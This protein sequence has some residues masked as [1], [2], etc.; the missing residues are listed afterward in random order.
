MRNPYC[1]GSAKWIVC[2][3]ALNNKLVDE[4]R[5]S[6]EQ[7]GEGSGNRIKQ[8]ILDLRSENKL[9]IKIEGN[10]LVYH[11]ER[12]KGMA[13]KV[14]IKEASKEMRLR[15]IYQGADIVCKIHVNGYQ[16][17]CICDD[18]ATDR[19]IYSALILSE[20]PKESIEVSL[21]AIKEHL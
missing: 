8:Y 16:G 9:D 20:K 13:E 7:L 4:V 12:E 10:R 6:L 2:E 1:V 3:G 19:T 17:T 14:R 18:V 5:N 15:D 11:G 21:N